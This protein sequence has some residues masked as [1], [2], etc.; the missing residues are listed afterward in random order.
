MGVDILTD[1]NGMLFVYENPRLVNI[2]MNKT[3]IPLDIIFI[4]NTKKIRSIKQGVPNTQKLISSEIDVMAVLELPKDCAKKLKIRI[5]DKINWVF[6]GLSEIK[7]IGYYH[8]LEAK[9]KIE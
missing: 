6:K 4:D 9:E 2:W 5:G 8:C 1:Y 3:K 7:N